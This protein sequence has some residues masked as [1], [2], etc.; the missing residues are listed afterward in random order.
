MRRFGNWRA[1]VFK[2]ESAV[3]ANARRSSGPHPA[4]QLDG[5]YAGEMKGESS[6]C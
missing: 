4:G 2:P 1:A 6:G 5:V 3:F